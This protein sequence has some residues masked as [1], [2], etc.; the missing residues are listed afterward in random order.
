MTEP[1]VQSGPY[2]EAAVASYVDA[3]AAVLGLSLSPE[4]RPGVITNLSFMLEQS[5]ALMAIDLDWDEEQA[6]VFVP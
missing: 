4:H 1:T 3:A 2:G 5:A 6:M